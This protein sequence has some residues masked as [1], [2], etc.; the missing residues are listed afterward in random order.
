MDA[1]LD[2]GGIRQI[3]D[4]AL[5]KGTAIIHAHDD[6]AAIFQIGHLSEGR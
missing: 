4:A 3:D 2:R 6:F 5:M 1:Q